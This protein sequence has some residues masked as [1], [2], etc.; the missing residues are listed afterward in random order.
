MTEI[1]PRCRLVGGRDGSSFKFGAACEICS[2]YDEISFF[3]WMN[4]TLDSVS[5]LSSIACHHM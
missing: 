3:S 2:K 5:A 1:T 4:L